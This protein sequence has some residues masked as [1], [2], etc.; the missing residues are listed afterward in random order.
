V[1]GGVGGVGGVVGVVGGGVGGVGGEV[2]EVGGEVGYLRALCRRTIKTNKEL[3]MDREYR[4][5]IKRVN[6]GY[7]LTT[8][9]TPSYSNRETIHPSV[10]SLFKELKSFVFLSLPSGKV[11]ETEEKE[12]LF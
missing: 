5:V 8:C 9:A 7:T 12:R 1:V 11:I 6:N 3:I 2:G 10:D 4:L